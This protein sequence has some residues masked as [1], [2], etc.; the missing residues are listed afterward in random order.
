MTD[1]SAHDEEMENL[2]ASE[3]FMFHVENRK[4]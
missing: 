2:M 4:L 3:I 1:A